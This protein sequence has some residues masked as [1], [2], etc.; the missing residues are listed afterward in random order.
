M[1]R[2]KIIIFLWFFL[3]HFLFGQEYKN[4]YSIGFFNSQNLS[5]PNNNRYLVN[6]AYFNQGLTLNFMR[7]VSSKENIRI[8]L[9]TG[10]SLS[11]YIN[12]YDTINNQ[13]LRIKE[14]YYSIPL[15]IYLKDVYDYGEFGV[16]LG[17]EFYLLSM[18]QFNLPN[19]NYLPVQYERTSEFGDKIDLGINMGLSYDFFLSAQQKTSVGVFISTSIS[20]L[21]IKQKAHVISHSTGFINKGI[22]LA[23]KF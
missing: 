8:M 10:I 3:P 9:S 2:K 5:K 15:G 12:E 19:N 17:T 6:N 13:V 21:N 22:R 16:F 20:V 7:V 23:K 14:G 1:N 11:S 4:E 18:Q